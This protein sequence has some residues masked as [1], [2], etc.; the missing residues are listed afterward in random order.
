[1]R[2]PSTRV[3]NSIF[4]SH[5]SNSICYRS[6][7]C[8]VSHS[9]YTA[10][11]R[12]PSQVDTHPRAKFST[13]LVPLNWAN[14]FSHVVFFTHWPWNRI[15]KTSISTQN[16]FAIILSLNYKTP[17]QPNVIACWSPSLLAIYLPTTVPVW[18]HTRRRIIH[19]VMHQIPPSHV[20]HHL[21]YFLNLHT[22]ITPPNPNLPHCASLARLCIALSTVGS[23]L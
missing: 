20:P 8:S 5:T 16:S 19:R 2:L 12:L 17:W 22:N 7:S 18:V 21:P 10:F 23:T 6:L 15:H 1:M 13:W 3:L 14:P 11:M 9:T 4:A